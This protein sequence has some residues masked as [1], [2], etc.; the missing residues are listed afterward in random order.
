MRQLPNLLTLVRLLL[1]PVIVAGLLN[2]QCLLPFVLSL[3]AGVTDAVD[4]ALAR[5]FGAISRAGAY[6]D[7]IA[8]KLLLVA[9]YVSFGLTNAVPAWLVWLVVG[10]D[11]LILLLVAAGY[12]LLGE[13]SFPPSI[14]GKLSTLVQIVAALL[15]LGRCLTTLPGDLYDVVVCA[16][17]MTTIW[18]GVHYSGR[19]LGILLRHRRA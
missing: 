2:G 4:G 8:D 3:T 16:V 12:W 19:A 14:W 6:L 5:R 10:R 1:T 7:P 17:A 9:L 15:I 11:L 13:R 18:S